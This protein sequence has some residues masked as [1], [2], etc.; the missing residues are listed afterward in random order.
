M[1]ELLGI[2]TRTVRRWS[3]AFSKALSPSARRRGRKR[4][5]DG[6]DVETFQRA[7]GLLD[8]GLDLE[9]VAERL[10]IVSPESRSTALTLST[11]ASL[12]LGQALERT[13]RLIDSVDDHDD[14]L[15]RLERWARSRRTWD[16]LPWWRRVGR[17]RPEL[18]D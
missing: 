5:F 2:S 15:D 18:E 10:P 8:E 3:I 17:Q 4:A 9:Q 13:S 14:R 16:V 7:S 11:E 6:G 1:A 12:A